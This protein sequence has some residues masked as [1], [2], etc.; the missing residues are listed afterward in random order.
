MLFSVATAHMWNRVELFHDSD[1]FN[2]AQLISD[3]PMKEG[4]TRFIFEL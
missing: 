4:K 3:E 1:Q 2:V